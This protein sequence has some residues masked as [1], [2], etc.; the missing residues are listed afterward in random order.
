METITPIATDPVIEHDALQQRVARLDALHRIQRA[1]TATLDLTPLLQGVVATVADVMASDACAIYLTDDERAALA[2][3]ATHGLPDGMVGQ[4]RLRVGEGIIGEAAARHDLIVA[5]DL[6][7]DPSGFRTQI[8][9]PLD[10]RMGARSVGV[11][12]L[13]FRDAHPLDD[14][15]RAFLHTIGDELSVA[16]DHARRYQA[17]DAELQRKVAE[18]QTLQR[19]TAVVTSTL[20][21]K[22]VLETIAEQAAML[23]Q[24]DVVSMYE[25]G[26]DG[27]TLTFL[28]GYEASGDGPNVREEVRREAVRR[29]IR[30]SQ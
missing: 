24:A 6:T 14:E 10:A 25:L 16:V 4:V 12:A 2:L 1:A 29:A 26:H 27:E 13:L 22:R 30:A 17:K 3:A 18:L 21:L 7:D 9:V 20:D 11:L 23:G 15:T 19:V 8:A 5:T 28:A